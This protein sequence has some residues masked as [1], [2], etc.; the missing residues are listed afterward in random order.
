MCLKKVHLF[1]PKNSLASLILSEKKNLFSLS[2]L[3]KTALHPLMKTTFHVFIFIVGIIRQ[4][5]HLSRLT[6]HDLY[7]DLKNVFLKNENISMKYLN[8]F[9]HHLVLYTILNLATPSAVVNSS[10]RNWYNNV[11]N[12]ITAWLITII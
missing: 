12:L 3:P 11:K 2:F 6:Q 5:T 9:L 1:I 7:F 8:Y 4:W 10:V